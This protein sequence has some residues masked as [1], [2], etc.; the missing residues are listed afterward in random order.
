M[1]RFLDQLKQRRV[2]R[3]VVAYPGAA[4]VMLEAVKFFIDNYDLDPRFLTSTIIVAAG[5]L[6][7]AVLWNWRHGEAGHQVV[8]KGEA[9]AYAV[10]G[11]AT[12]VAVGW[13]WSTTPT[14]VRTASVAPPPARSIAV[15]PFTNA[16]GDDTVQYLCDGIAESLTNWL[17][18]VPNVR[19]VSKTAAFRLRD[20]AD[21]IPAIV[22]ALGV[23][24]VVRGKLETVDGN[25][26][27]SA[28][29]VDTRD[30]AQL[31]GERLV[32]PLNDVIYL[33]RSIV[34]AI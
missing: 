19:V 33:E 10:I 21:D 16:S 31:W 22:E 13:Y 32:Q 28:S 12:L 27:V 3:V 8:S 5:L 17:A 14:V 7:A 25:V 20:Q 18:S 11:A 15:L 9:G 26:I 34:A 29:L 4:Y 23:D 6:P 1:G 24:S 2:W 30:D